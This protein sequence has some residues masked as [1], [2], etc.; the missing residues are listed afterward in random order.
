MSLIHQCKLSPK[1][2]YGLLAG[3]GLIPLFQSELNQLK[4]AHKVR[5]Y[6]EKKWLE[7]V[8]KLCCPD[9][10]TRN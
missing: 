3:I 7:N 2:A 8:F 5:G 10:Y 4:M 1:W 9:V 6:E